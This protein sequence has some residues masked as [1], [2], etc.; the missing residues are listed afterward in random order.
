MRRAEM[1]MARWSRSKCVINFPTGEETG[2][3]LGNSVA[4]C[5]SIEEDLKIEHK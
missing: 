3:R 1:L 4:E 5:F 2:P